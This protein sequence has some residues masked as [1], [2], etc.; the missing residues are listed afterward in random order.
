V[1]LPDAL[2]AA[3]GALPAEAE[4]IR[5]ANGDPR[6]LLEKLD[7]EAAARVLHWL[8]VHRTE[9]A[10]ELAEAWVEAPEGVRAL[11]ACSREGLPKAG[12]KLLRRLHH[13]LRSQGVNVAEPAPVPTVATLPKLEEE[14]SGAWLSPLDPSGARLAYLL[15]SNPSGGA[16]IFELVFDDAQGILGF[17]VYA[18][19]RGRARRFLKELTGRDRAVASEAPVEAV[20]ALL[21][22]ALA[23]Q[24]PDRSPPRTFSEWRSHLTR[25]SEDDRLPGALVLEALG[26]D[27]DATAQE[28]ALQLVEEG[29]IGPWP[30]QRDVLLAVFERIRNAM[31][32]PLIVSGATRREQLEGLL[33]DAVEEIFD[34]QGCALAVHR[35]RE[36][37]YTLWKQGDVDAARACLAGAASLE[38]GP[39]RESP[40]ARLLLELP[41]RPALTALEVAEES[42][43]READAGESLIVKP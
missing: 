26:D 27:F 25:A 42:D 33:A 22:Q 7:A 34:A 18:A 1:S 2:E 37:A 17:E 8:L 4:V 43:P 38:L 30:P 9:E 35:L 39:V 6:R 31:E 29:R 15:E 12:R 16:R 13:R 3:A 36:S 24:R 5:P 32:S 20:H 21:A 28:R 14:L 10:Q 40:L 19:P 23:H 41:L 11:Q